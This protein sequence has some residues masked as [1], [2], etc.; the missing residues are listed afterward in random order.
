MAKAVQACAG[1]KKGSRARRDLVKAIQDGGIQ[2]AVDQQPH[3]QG[4]LA[5]DS[6]WL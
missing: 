6:L 5:V 4:H 2:F 3:L 1:V